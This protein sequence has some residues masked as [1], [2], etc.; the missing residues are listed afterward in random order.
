MLGPT[1][2]LKEKWL[3][4]LNI[5]V[6]NKEE[7][8]PALPGNPLSNMEIVGT[9]KG[10]NSGG[11]FG[12]VRNT[13]DNCG[14]FK[15]SEGYIEILGKKKMHDGFDL[16]ADLKTPIYAMYDGL[17]E[18][19]G[20]RKNELG[21]VIYIISS[22]DQHKKSD[23]PIRITYC[24][25]NSI[26]KLGKEVKQGQLIGYTGNSGNAKGID[27]WRYHLHLQVYNTKLGEKINPNKFLNTKFN[28]Y[29]GNKK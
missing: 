19:S 4:Y 24:H 2:I 10:D 25:L 3:G 9:E 23:Y 18:Y 5:I 28:I 1:S 15:S 7:E 16:K 20:D 12:C 13:A 8:M 29:D 21:L 14:N 27:E 22:Q 26:E 17:V 11:V 6:E